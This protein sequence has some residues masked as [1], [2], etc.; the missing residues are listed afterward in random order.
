MCCETLALYRTI[1][2]AYA[3]TGVLAA[4]VMFRAFDREMLTNETVSNLIS[5]H[6]QFRPL[7]IGLALSF[8]AVI[9]AAWPMCIVCFVL[10]K[11]AIKA[12]AITTHQKHIVEGMEIPTDLL[13]KALMERQVELLREELRAYGYESDPTPEGFECWFCACD[14]ALPSRTFFVSKRKGPLYLVTY[15]C[16]ERVDVVDFEEAFRLI[17]ETVH[18]VET[19]TS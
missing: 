18:A 4:I 11:V 1:F 2:L 9:A 7:V 19:E 16:A 3:G 5:A 17:E 14:D 15:S 13:H 6:A 12:A 8:A 10:L